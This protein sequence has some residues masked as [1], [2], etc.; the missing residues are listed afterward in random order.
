MRPG[1]GSA[2]GGYTLIELLLV[3]IIGAVLLSMAIPSFTRMTAGQNARNARDAVVWMAARARSRAIERGEVVLLEIDPPSERAWI[4]R[5]NTGTA[6]ASDTLE[7]T[8]FGTEQSVTLSTTSNNRLTLCY[9][10]R[11]YAFTCSGNSP[12]SNQNVTFL[13]AGKSAIAV[14]KPLGQIERL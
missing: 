13:H 12:G 6:L 10:P 5:R 7:K 9:S 4:V 1:I 14:V 3:M 8:N 2:R 11:G